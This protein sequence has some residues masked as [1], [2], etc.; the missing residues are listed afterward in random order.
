M[1]GHKVSKFVESRKLKKGLQVVGDF[2]HV[3]K[4]FV[5]RGKFSVILSGVG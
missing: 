4:M 2:V 3:Y 5:E 1:I